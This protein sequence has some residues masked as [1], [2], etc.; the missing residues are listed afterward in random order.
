[1]GET[2]QKRRGRS[3]AAVSDGLG[4]FLL[5]IDLLIA[6]RERDRAQWEQDPF[7]RAFRVAHRALAELPPRP[8]VGKAA[9]LAAYDA[10]MKAGH[11]WHPHR[12]RLREANRWVKAIREEMGWYE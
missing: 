9:R 12:S 10:R 7:E 8:V 2:R 1:V 4:L 11:A 5:Q 6:T 3:K